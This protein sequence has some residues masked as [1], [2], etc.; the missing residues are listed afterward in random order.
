MNTTKKKIEALNEL[1]KDE[2]ITPTFIYNEGWMLRLVL[3]WLS[4]NR[5]IKHE[6]AFLE[7]SDWFSEAALKTV[8]K[9]NKRGDKLSETYTH[10]D[11]VYGF[12]IPPDKGK[13]YVKLEND[14][15]QFVVVEAKM[16]SKFSKGT[17]NAPTY[18]QAA[19]IVACMCNIVN[20]QNVDNLAF[21]TFLP[22]DQ[23][24]DEKTFQKFTDKGNIKEEVGKRVEQYGEMTKWYSDTF[25][26][27][28]EKIQIK[29]VSWES[30]LELVKNEDAET[31]TMLNSFYEKC[32]DHNQK[33]Q[34]KK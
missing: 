20:N 1:I 30:I 22:K 19:R 15:K 25:C 32:I 34:N 9:A 33:K 4:E 24:K 28:L 11:G 27:F 12:I 5:E 7:N 16:F 8:F 29:L 18:N 26:P 14:C 31:Y 17:K 6:L 10:A 13:G 23:I 2:K 21:Y 3:N